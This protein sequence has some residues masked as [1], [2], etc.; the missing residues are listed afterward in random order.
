MSAGRHSGGP[1]REVTILRSVRGYPRG[2]SSLTVI[3]LD[4]HPS[5]SEP[6]VTRRGQACRRLARV[7]AVAALVGGQAATALA[8]GGPVSGGMT[9]T[10]RFTPTL[11]RPGYV[12]VTPYAHVL[13]LVT[14][15]SANVLY[16]MD[17]ETPSYVAAYDLARLKPTARHGTLL[18]GT[19]SASLVDP[20]H[21]GVVVALSAAGR[22][23]PTTAIE[24][25]GV[26][27]SAPAVKRRLAVA[28]GAI[29]TNGVI[30]G[31]A[32]KRGSNLLFVA[33]MS[34]AEGLPVPGTVRLSLLDLS[35]R[36]G[37]AGVV[38]TQPLTG[39][40]ALM[41]PLDATTGTQTAL[42]APIGYVASR[43]EVD[44][45]CSSVGSAG[46]SE[47]APGIQTGVGVAVLSSAEIPVYG[48]FAI[49]PFPGNTADAPMGLWFPDGQRLAFQTFSSGPGGAWWI[50]DGLHHAYVGGVSTGTQGA[51]NKTAAVG[52]DFAHGRIYLEIGIAFG[53]IAADITPT[54]IDQG[55]NY[56]DFGPDPLPGT[57]HGTG[58]A[59]EVPS[60]AV[61]STH[62]RIFML[63]T[64]EPTFA[65][66][67]D[68]VPHFDATAQGSNPDTATINRAE[69]AGVTGRTF[70]AAAQAYGAIY[71][72]VGGDQNLAYNAVPISTSDEAQRGTRQ[73]SLA[74]LDRFALSENSANAAAISAI[75]D[76]DNTQ[77]QLAQAQQNWPYDDAICSNYGGKPTS[78]HTVGVTVTC[79]VAGG[80]AKSSIV[81]GASGA[82]APNAPAGPD[83]VSVSESDVT[84][85]AG[86]DKRLGLVTKVTATARGI[87]LLAGAVQ[88][89]EATGTA[90]AR[91]HGR[92]GTAGTTFS[93][94]FAD[95]TING[96]SVCLSSCDVAAVAAQINSTFAGRLYVELPR[97]D[98]LM[99]KGTPGGF[100]SAI[101]RDVFSQAQETSLNDQPSAR[102]EVPALQVTIREDNSVPSRTVVYLAGVEAESHYGIYLLDCT[103]CGPHAHPPTSAPV[104]GH[105]PGA[106]NPGAP[107]SLPGHSTGGVVAGPPAVAP[108]PSGVAGMLKHGWDIAISGLVTA[109]R[110]FGVWAILLAPVYL[111]ARR[112]LLTGRPGLSTAA[113]V[114]ES[115]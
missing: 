100:Q 65:V 26:H 1:I 75:P 82:S 24:E 79:D 73:L 85:T 35:G 62:D 38:W 4:P 7:V 49:D 22:G 68:S 80:S 44:L 6:N 13:R 11:V 17:F 40:P 23:Q 102:L 113:A 108:T 20:R 95:V 43:H 84:A 105:Q 93:R 86:V 18:D 19:I 83:V 25:L 27:H 104:G 91:A 76:H 52:G 111:S 98:A 106:G 56:P 110:L 66:L 46:T 55:H 101:Q 47:K 57:Y 3:R 115:S 39:C 69:A 96:K 53:L 114:K 94:G 14:D 63:Y 33:S 48:S 103:T 42:T 32:S 97:P 9:L 28:A 71:R 112:W 31:L 107:G 58:Y 54:P 70:S 90:T 67:H 78:T 34:Y 12:S 8:S 72:Q 77:H 81:G 36:L 21:A 2:L 109:L 10:G 87:N 88:I 45:G 99:R 92:P 29:G 16:T 30:L 74:W 5:E 64:G 60:I 41:I 61:D 50:F 51:H 59:S 89:G 37:T 15:Q